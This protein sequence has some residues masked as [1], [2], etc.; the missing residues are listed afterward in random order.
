MIELIDRAATMSNNAD[1][2]LVT[3]TEV[4]SRAV[5]KVAE[6][7]TGYPSISLEVGNGT[8][9]DLGKVN[10][11]KVWLIQSEMGAGGPGGAHETVG[12]AIREVNPEEVIMG[13]IAFGS[14]REKH[15]IGD[16][17]VA[18][19]LHMYEPQR[20]GTDRVVPRGDKV[21]ASPRLL[22]RLRNASLD[23]KTANVHFGL[24]LSGEKLIDDDEFVRELLSHEPEAIG[25]EMEGAGL[26]VPCLVAKK[27]WILVKAVCDWADGNKSKDKTE[28]Q[29]KA[30]RNA[31][32]FVWHALAHAPKKSDDQSDPDLPPRLPNGAGNHLGG[33]Y[34]RPTPD[35]TSDRATPALAPQ[36]VTIREKSAAEIIVNLKGGP[37]HLFFE[38]AKDLY[39][40]RW[41]REPGWQ[42]IVHDLPSKR[43]GGGWRCHF[44]EV[45]SGPLV[46]AS[47]VQDLSAL[48]LGDSVTVSG[49]ISDV[50]QLGFVTLEDAI[51]LGD[52]VPLPQGRA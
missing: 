14:N 1:I 52:H 28:R 13:G 19:Q 12:Q 18:K 22:Q 31:A 27:D 9:R 50:S 3:A 49:R 30:A 34:H 2:L 24:V 44:I 11:K 17:L 39:I 25:G 42:A 36:R 48:R 7:F 26:Y 47:T 20:R 10:G 51:V 32:H 43:S 45:G 38:K 8:Y 40:R 46:A 29:L 6:E 35:F 16:V 21:T 37:A 4:E 15:E 33:E 41:T 23:W 5:L